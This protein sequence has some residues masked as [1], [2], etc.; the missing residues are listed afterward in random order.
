MDAQQ[1]AKYNRNHKLKLFLNATAAIFTAFIPFNDAYTAM[2][3]LMTSLEE[4]I[5][6]QQT[7][8]K[9]PS[10]DKRN[11]KKAMAT[12]WSEVA[13]RASVKFRRDNNQT[14]FDELNTPESEIDGLPDSEAVAK[15]QQIH[16]ILDENLA[17]LAG[18][19]IDADTLTAGTAITNAFHELIGKPKVIQELKKVAGDKIVEFLKEIDDQIDD[20]DRLI[21]GIEDDD[22][23][24]G[25][26]ANKEIDD[27]ATK[28]TRL[29]GVMY[30]QD[31]E[32]VQKGGTIKII[33]I[34]RQTTSNNLGLYEI[35]KF[36]AGIY[37]VEYSAPGKVTQ[38][39][40]ITFKLGKT[41]EMD[42]FMVDE[43]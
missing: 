34:N 3:A 28:N 41:V 11:A 6:K 14:L 15:C 18:Y 38:Q 9:G 43:E 12:F 39:H 29:K 36:K 37:I 27:P 30:G 35:F 10:A 19:L 7:D 16:A 4:F 5:T 42:V 23:K 1:I 26:E 25:F 21:S 33:D 20:M 17:S 2:L 8:S 31:E 22:F 40:T 32:T 24:E 13:L